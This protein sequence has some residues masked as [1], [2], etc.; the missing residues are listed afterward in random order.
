MSPPSADKLRPKTVIPIAIGT[1]MAMSRTMISFTTK[2][3][4]TPNNTSLTHYRYKIKFLTL[5]CMSLKKN[6]PALIILLLLA[7]SL[8][9]QRITDI[10]QKN[11]N[12]FSNMLGVNAFEWDFLQDPKNPNDPTHIYEPKM[13]IMEAFGGFRHYLDWQKTEHAKG[14]YT[15]NPTNNGGWNLDA[16]YQRCKQDNI[17]V[18][19]CLKGCPDWLLATY[20]MKLRD[21]ENVPMPFGSNKLDPASYADQARNAFQFAAR[22]GSNKN[23]NPA[24]VS[25]DSSPRWTA[26]PVNVV[27]IGMGLIKYIECDNERDKWWKDDKA[28]QSAEEYAANLSAFYDGDKGRLGKNA[29]VKNA[30]PNLQVVMAGLANPDPKYVQDMITWCKIHRGY[31]ADGSVNLCFDVINFHFY[32]N[33]HRPGSTDMGTVGVA[34]EQSEAGQLAD[35]F[36]RIGKAYHL[37][38]WVTEAGYDINPGSPQRAI[39]IGNK[40][41]LI[42]Q[43]DWIIRTSFLYARHGI[44]KLFFYEL[45]DD[46]GDNPTQYESSGLA[47]KTQQRRPAADY[48]YQAKHL[49]G[50]MTYKGTIDSDP[51]I[52]VYR[53]GNRTVYALMLPSQSGETS[54]CILNLGRATNAVVYRFNPGSDD[55]LKT[56]VS[57]SNHNLKVKVSETPVFVEKMD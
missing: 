50:D 36:V 48:I 24:L 51:L 57:A 38:V 6:I 45:Y 40:S 49:L 55:M 32:S 26:D 5:A 56:P 7:I 9:A 46:N 47:T 39:A 25:V 3:F 33:N 22:Y 10:P 21:G 31:K 42:T 30:D 11:T 23:V 4:Y 18:L 20:P 34:P 13:K 27:K 15:F 16:I 43:A 53:K 14:L 17:E 19:V 2:Y 41:A 35:S 1:M 54:S 28:Q 44:S 29:G 12:T 37:P 8:K 52:D